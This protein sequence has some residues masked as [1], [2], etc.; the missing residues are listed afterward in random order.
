MRCFQI[1]LKHNLLKLIQDGIENMNSPILHLQ[2][3][4]KNIES[5][6]SDGLSGE[7]YQ[8]VA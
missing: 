1:P 6:K 8:A 2:I 5:Y 7:Y 4:D 3:C